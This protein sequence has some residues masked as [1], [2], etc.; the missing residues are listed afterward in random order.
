V[1][2][3]PFGDLYQNAPK[4]VVHGSLRNCTS[5]LELAKLAESKGFEVSFDEGGFANDIKLNE[6]FDSS[7]PVRNHSVRTAKRFIESHPGC[8]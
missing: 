6:G 5:V 3:T 7:A 1:T 8:A 4:F 2:Y